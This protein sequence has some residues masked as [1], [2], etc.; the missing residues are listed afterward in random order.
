MNAPC[1]IN[2]LRTTTFV[3]SE[4]LFCKLALQA[5]RTGMKKLIWQEQSRQHVFFEQPRAIPRVSLGD[6]LSQNTLVADRFVAVSIDIIIDGDSV[7][8]PS[9]LALRST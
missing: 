7:Y 4:A 2:P 6:I 9:P 8:E 1:V 5:H 3:S